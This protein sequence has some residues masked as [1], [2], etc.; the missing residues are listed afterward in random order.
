MGMIIPNKS[1]IAEEEIEVPY[2]REVR[3]SGSTARDRERE[4]VPRGSRADED[5]SDYGEDEGEENGRPG[6]LAALSARLQAVGDEDEE[7]GRSG[8][9]YFDKVSMGRTSAASD[10]SYA[11]GGRNS[12]GAE[13]E[14]RR[15]YEYKIATMQQRITGLEREVEESREK[16]RAWAKGEERVRAV[17]DELRELRH[18]G[19]NG[20]VQRNPID[21]CLQRMEEKTTAM[22]TLQQEL[23]TLRQERAREQ[24]AAARRSREDEEELQILRERCER[25]EEE[26]VGGGQVSGLFITP[27]CLLNVVI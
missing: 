20:C 14:L 10:R 12:V 17:E 21:N 8:E 25:L 23:E 1:T 16:E 2:G 22:F 3:E 5:R 24:E 15:E 26:R 6:G 27:M 9:D 19:V 11:R 7:A 13:E 18:V 4:R